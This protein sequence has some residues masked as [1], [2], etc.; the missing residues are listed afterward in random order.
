MQIIYIY[1]VY[2][3]LYTSYIYSYG[4]Y[5]DSCIY[6]SISHLG[7]CGGAFAGRRAWRGAAA[8]AGLPGEEAAALAGAHGGDE[9]P[10]GIFHRRLRWPYEI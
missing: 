4:H 2:N 8:A 7:P 1:Y 9:V 5:L 10:I 6:T 3:M